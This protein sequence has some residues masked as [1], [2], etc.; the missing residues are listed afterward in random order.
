MSTKRIDLTGMRIG[1]LLVIR[2]KKERNKNG[3][4]M[5]ECLCS[6]G[7]KKNI[8][9]SSLRR[10]T[11]SC[12]C[13]QKEKASK[14]SMEGTRTYKAWISM[15]S[16]CVNY[17]NKRYKD[18]GGRGITVCEKWMNDFN[19]FFLDMGEAPEGCSID[20]IDNNMGYSAEN[21]RWATPKEQAN[22][23]RS[24]VKVIIDGELITVEEYSK[25]VCLTVSGARKQLEREFTRIDGVF[26]KSADLTD[27]AI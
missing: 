26:V 27:V 15:K 18:Y 1:R 6:C 23:R 7:N 24:N 17:N 12:G 11:K 4:I 13:L 21:C 20:R 19:S 14:H 8:L 5:Y 2:E 25:I 10:S 22:N 9:G 3:H 16:R